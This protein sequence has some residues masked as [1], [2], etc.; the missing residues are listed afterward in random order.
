MDD[1]REDDITRGTNVIKVL[2]R[3]A[4]TVQEENGDNPSDI[5]EQPRS[6]ALQEEKGQ[7]YLDNFAEARRSHSPFKSL[8]NGLAT[9]PAYCPEN[10]KRQH[11]PLHPCTNNHNQQHT[12]LGRDEEGLRPVKENN[13]CKYKDYSKTDDD[14]EESKWTKLIKKHKLC[15]CMDCSTKDEN[16]KTMM[17]PSRHTY[18]IAM[19]STSQKTI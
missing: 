8:L 16:Y 7:G 11:I 13:L 1:A 5:T 9:R 6:K 18:H 3:Y 2:A 15:D 12:G 10:P 17:V 4:S 19:E 14:T